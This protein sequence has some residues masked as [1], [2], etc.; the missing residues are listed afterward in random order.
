MS[1]HGASIIGNVSDEID[2]SVVST[3]GENVNAAAAISLDGRVPIP[4]VSASRSAPQKPAVSSSA[5]HK[6]WVTQLGSP[7]VWPSRK[8]APCGNR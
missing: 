6:R 8:N 3:R 4:S 5:H 2:P 1:T 7:M